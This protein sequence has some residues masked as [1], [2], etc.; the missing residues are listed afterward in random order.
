[1]LIY[2][3]Y[4]PLS[5]GKPLISTATTDHLILPISGPIK[6]STR[7]SEPFRRNQ[8]SCCCCCCVIIGH[9][10]DLCVCVCVSL[11]SAVCCQVIDHY[12]SS[13]VGT[14]DLILA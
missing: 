11:L 8:L 2:H 14:V 9:W 10:L 13:I 6:T 5:F 1:M 3:H 7:S 4:R 12:H